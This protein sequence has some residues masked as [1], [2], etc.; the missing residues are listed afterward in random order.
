LN[1][2]VTDAGS[3]DSAP[4][5][6]VDL[7]QNGGFPLEIG[8]TGSITL[9][10]SDAAAIQFTVTAITP[11]FTC[12]APEAVSPDNGQFIAVTMAFTLSADYLGRMDAATPLH[13]NQ[14]DW[15]GF[16][17]DENGTQ[18]DNTDTGSSCIAEAEQFPAE[19]AAGTDVSGTIVLD[20]QTDVASL[21]WAPTGVTDLDPGMTRWEWTV[22]A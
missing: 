5:D 19:F 14:S 22:P 16:V 13:M 7:T 12:T 4:V 1:G 8:D 2:A 21:S 3:D 6:E 17:A 15:I 9:A 10:D 11:N 20:M 18:V